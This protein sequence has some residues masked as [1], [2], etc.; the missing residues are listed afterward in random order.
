MSAPL[1]NLQNA[2]NTNTLTSL[3]QAALSQA[4]SVIIPLFPPI[5]E[6]AVSNPPPDEF[7]AR[8]WIAA[9]YALQS[10]GSGGG[11]VPGASGTII[12]ANI[13]AM[14]AIPAAT[15]IQGQQAFVQSN[16]STWTLV[17]G[18][19]PTDG[20]TI[21]NS[22]TPGLQWMRENISGYLGAYLEQTAWFVDPVAGNDEN[23]GLTSGSALKTKAEI[24]RR[25]GYTWS[26]TLD[27]VQVT[28][29]YLNPD[30]TADDPALFAPNF[31]NGALLLETAPLPAPS[32]TGTL[33]VVTAKN[34]AANQPL[35]AT[36]TVAT[37]AVVKDML[38]VNAT[39]G[40]SVAF[41]NALAAGLA[42]IDQPLAA[43]PAGPLA[44]PTTTNVDTWAHGD[45]ITGYVLLKV[46]IGVIGGIVDT[47]DAPN[48]PGQHW[49]QNIDIAD[50]AGTGSQCH[51]DGRCAP[52]LL[53]CVL[54]KPLTLSRT[55]PTL[56][57]FFVG[58]AFQGFFAASAEQGFAY[59]IAGGH[60]ESSVNCVAG[61][62]FSNAPSFAGSVNVYNGRISDALFG[63]AAASL[64]TRG[65]CVVAGPV[66][67]ALPVNAQQ[68]F[69]SY[70]A[71]AATA[72]PTSGGIAING[73]ANAYSN[74]TTAGVVATHKVALSPANLDAAA[75]AAGFGGLA[76][77]PG[78][79]GFTTGAVP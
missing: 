42:T 20:I 45:T 29:T 59:Q 11:P 30:T 25:W 27:T 64:T 26:P 3:Q 36:F 77:I 23:G 63:T 46:D 34:A 55:S 61:A 14:V 49:V 71:P 44:F 9:L 12:V 17:P 31:K 8:E 2:I 66:F 6:T 68:G 78:V 67:G 28:I 60:F 1:V 16:G 41:V 75:G 53:N 22:V 7:I 51:A 40:Y 58:C 10:E 48:Y 35:Q 76:Y 54:G 24:F 15:L 21:V 19:G 73:Q 39:R 4:L 47:F 79:G 50:V 38:L 74:L 32:F 65:L 72:F 43:Q 13:A 18:S 33:N 69:I 70:G 57:S 52:V 37:G 5:D 56:Q 62:T